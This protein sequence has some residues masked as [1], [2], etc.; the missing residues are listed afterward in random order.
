MCADFADVQCDLLA[1]M[2]CSCAGCCRAS[3]AASL[4]ADRGLW[5][6]G[7]LFE[8][9][10]HLATNRSGGGSSSGSG[11]GDGSGSGSGSSNSAKGGAARREAEAAG[12]G[13][14]RNGTTQRPLEAGEVGERGERGGR[15]EREES[16]Q[17]SA[18]V[19]A[20][21]SAAAQAA[22][23][24][25]ATA[26]AAD[27]DLMALSEAASLEEAALDRSEAGAGVCSARCVRSCL[28]SCSAV[29]HE[30]GLQESEQCYTR[31]TAGAPTPL[32][33]RFQIPLSGSAAPYMPL[34]AAARVEC[35]TAARGP[36]PCVCTLT[37]T[38]LLRRR[39]L[40]LVLGG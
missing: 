36:V 30:K 8:H 10:A 2:R 33:S 40:T 5:S 4:E 28:Q 7:S 9:A 16:F 18:A 35:C 37:N 20:E 29:F 12:G 17:P 23:A 19:A 21:A 24:A 22:A 25:A 26:A 6:G 3:A 38:P 31:C 14:S 11:S 34:A 27:I 13:A 39:L 32:E 1:Q 15:G